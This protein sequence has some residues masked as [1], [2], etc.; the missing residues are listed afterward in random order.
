MG[1]EA[2]LCLADEVEAA[3]DQDQVLFADGGLCALEGFAE[4]QRGLPHLAGNLRIEVGL[5]L[6]IRVGL[7]AFLIHQ[8]LLFHCPVCERRL[9][10]SPLPLRQSRR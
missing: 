1:L 10:S 6:R 3:G 9:L 2:E 7:V 4:A 5:F 8:P